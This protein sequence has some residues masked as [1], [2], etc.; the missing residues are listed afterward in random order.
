MSRLSR[1]PLGIVSKGA[2]APVHRPVLPLNQ[3]RVLGP[4]SWTSRKRHLCQAE[5]KRSTHSIHDATATVLDSHVCAFPFVPGDLICVVPPIISPHCR[6]CSLRSKSCASLGLGCACDA[7]RSLEIIFGA[8]NRI[9]L[10]QPSA[11]FLHFDLSMY[12]RGMK[13]TSRHLEQ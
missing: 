12:P 8:A 9:L 3:L 2:S 13:S 5:K 10:H 1:S 11:A 4:Q 6:C 7:F